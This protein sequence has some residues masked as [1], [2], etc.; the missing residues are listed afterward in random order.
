ML[1]EE[2]Q[3]FLGTLQVG[4][5]KL[6]S[7]RPLLPPRMALVENDLASAGL[8]DGLEAPGLAGQCAQNSDKA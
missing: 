2:P 5:A 7:L 8:W 6:T 4:R 3:D 1:C